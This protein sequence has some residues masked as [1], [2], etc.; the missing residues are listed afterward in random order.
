MKFGVANAFKIREEIRWAAETL[1]RYRISSLAILRRADRDAR[2]MFIKDLREIERRSFPEMQLVRHLLGHFAPPKVKQRPNEKNPA[3]EEI[4]LATRLGAQGN[5]MVYFRGL[6]AFLK[7]TQDMANFFSQELGRGEN[8]TP[9]YAPF[10][11]PD[12]AKAP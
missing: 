12:V 3:I 7:P 5:I 10:I 2:A 11:V 8:K 1:A 4:V 6:S 9:S